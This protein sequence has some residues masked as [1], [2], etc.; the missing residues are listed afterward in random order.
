M[1]Q[2][3]RIGFLLAVIALFVIGFFQAG[4]YLSNPEQPPVRADV[5]LALGGGIGDR[6]VMAAKL[7][8]QGYAPRVLLTGL[9]HSPGMTRSNYLNWRVKFL[10]DDNVPKSMII[11]DRISRNS[12]EEAVNT[13]ALL[14]Q[15]GWNRV[16]VVSDPPHM[17]RL[18]WVWGKVFKGSG[19][20][21]VL[22]SSAPVWWN[23]ARWWMH[24]QSASFV[25]MEYIKLIFYFFKY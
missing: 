3:V 8:H 17:R 7:Y 24:D 13:L 18:H 14:K 12:W 5:I 15:H 4:N 11:L 21:F 23:P 20:K 10:L 1:K 6:V 25:V 19:K 2:P 9:E 22:V 16:I